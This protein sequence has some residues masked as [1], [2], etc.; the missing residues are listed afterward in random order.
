MIRVMLRIPKIQRKQSLSRQSN[1]AECGY[2]ERF[3][4][5]IHWPAIIVFDVECCMRKFTLL[6]IIPGLAACLGSCT[7][8]Q[9]YEA[10]LDGWIGKTEKELVMS[11]GIPDKQYQISQNSKMVSYISTESAVYPSGLSTCFGAVNGN[12]ITTNCMGNLPPVVQNYYCE[13][14]FTL[15]DGHIDRWGHKGNDCR[16]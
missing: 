5:F 2:Q 15:V 6:F 1:P 8:T 13:T 10:S 7:T 16:S 14:F 11:W 9:N 3:C 4:C 12:T